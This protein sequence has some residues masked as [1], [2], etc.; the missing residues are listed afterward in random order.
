MKKED[1]EKDITEYYI[2]LYRNNIELIKYA[3]RTSKEQYGNLSRFFDLD[4]FENFYKQQ[5]TL[6]KEVKKIWQKNKR[7]EKIIGNRN[8]II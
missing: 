2:D 6:I 5:I 1:K 8:T 4:F 7:Q 3:K